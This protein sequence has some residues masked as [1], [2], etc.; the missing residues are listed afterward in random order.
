MTAEEYASVI[1]KLLIDN[2]DRKDLSWTERTL[3]VLLRIEL[4]RQNAAA[5]QAAEE[6][7]KQY[8]HGYSR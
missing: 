4:D 6:R 8:S 3:E 1:R 2:Y 7:A 5:V